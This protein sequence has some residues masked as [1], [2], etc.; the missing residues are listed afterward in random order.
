M[1]LPEQVKADFYAELLGLARK[2]SPSLELA[3]VCI[4]E[5]F[6]KLNGDLNKYDT[7]EE[8]RVSLYIQ[9]LKSSC[10]GGLPCGIVG[11]SEQKRRLMQSKYVFGVNEVRFRSK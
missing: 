1:K 2:Y 4:V 9:L 10:L 8:V 11:A 3:N 6:D 5:I 7:I